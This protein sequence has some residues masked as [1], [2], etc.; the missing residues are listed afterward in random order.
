M[1][2]GIPE[3]DKQPVITNGT[4]RTGINRSI[5]GDEIIGSNADKSDAKLPKN[6]PLWKKKRNAAIPDWNRPHFALG[7]VPGLK[8]RKC[9]RR[10]KEL[11]L[12]PTKM[13]TD[14]SETSREI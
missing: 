4:L 2:S 7:V 14:L 12:I 10:G 9:P 5:K 3:H 11:G 8:F 6:L 13:I 1:G